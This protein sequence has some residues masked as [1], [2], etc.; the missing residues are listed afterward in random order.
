MYSYPLPSPEDLLLLENYMNEVMPVLIVVGGFFFF[1]SEY[2]FLR[3]GLNRFPQNLQISW[4]WSING[5]WGMTN[6][7]KIPEPLCQKWWSWGTEWWLRTEKGLFGQREWMKMVPF[8]GKMDDE[9][10]TNEMVLWFPFVS[11]AHT[12]RNC[13]RGGLG[14]GWL[15]IFRDPLIIPKP[16]ILPL[17]VYVL[18][19]DPEKHFFEKLIL[20]HRTEKSSRKI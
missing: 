19:H 5:G 15:S 10:Y 17:Y 16:F 7:Q 11:A 12:P 20:E 18:M 1:F 13:N 2:G 4:R 3:A 6:W 8:A 14:G 9:K